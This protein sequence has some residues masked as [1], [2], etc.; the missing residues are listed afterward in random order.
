MQQIKAE[1]QCDL[2]N[3]AASRGN[4]I[5]GSEIVKKKEQL[6]RVF[7]LWMLQIKEENTVVKWSVEPLL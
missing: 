2:T 4:M 1:F 5:Q 3:P 7:V 6:C